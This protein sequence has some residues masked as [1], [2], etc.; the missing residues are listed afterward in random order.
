MV[1]TRARRLS[2]FDAGFLYQETPTAHMHTLKVALVDPATVPQGYS[3]ELLREVLAG[4]MHLL[5]PFTRRILPV[6]GGL[7]HPVW[8]EDP[9]FD[10]DNHLFRVRLPAPGG[11]RELGA[12]ISEVAG[13]PLARHRPL[14]EIHVVE[15]L[16]RGR[17][18]C[19]AKVHHALADGVSSA[20]M[21]LAV[22]GE[23]AVATSGRRPPEPVPRPATLLAVALV[24][25]ASLFRTLPR[26]LRRTTARLVEMNRRARQSDVRAPRP[27]SGPRT[28]FNGAL[29]AERIFAFASL[30]LA[31]ARAIRRA[32]GTTLNDV[33]MAVCAGALRAWLIGRETPVT[34]PLVVGV[35]VSTRTAEQRG[36]Y[37]N[38]VSNM[39]TS[40]PIHLDD[41]H[42][43]LLAISRVN[44]V[45]KDQTDALGNDSFEA[46]S[47]Y[48]PPPL[49]T[50]WA[51]LLGRLRLADRGPA[52][53]NLIIS[54]VAGPTS[55]LSIAG[56][57]LEAIYSVGPILEGVGLNITMW[58]YLGRMNFGLLSCPRLVPDLWDLADGLADALSELAGAVDTGHTPKS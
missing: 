6:P 33:V 13:Q 49:V 42:A 10:L 55:V 11:S 18:A 43:R 26:Q 23:T 52:P 38:R 58:S 19:I 53:I 12:V 20:E 1:V 50:L 14:W 56:A 54:N 40:L 41:P 16:E 39:F 8:I 5:P 22:M 36:T 29:T 31:D 28:P 45:A 32:T 25:L 47:E 37:G 9:D 51:R 35:P 30:D 24:D 3:F 15:G 27:F 2:G 7:H 34:D 21:L 44:R 48:T 46:L 17:I 57:Q 4:R